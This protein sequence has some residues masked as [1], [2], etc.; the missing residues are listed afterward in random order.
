MLTDA[1]PCTAKPESVNAKAMAACLDRTRNKSHP[2]SAQMFTL[3][4]GPDALGQR[5]RLLLESNDLSLTYAS[6]D[7]DQTD[8]LRAARI[9]SLSE[10]G[11]V[12]ATSGARKPSYS[13]FAP[14]CAGRAVFCPTERPL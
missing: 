3:P 9:V 2:P 8:A 7:S 1:L 6:S 10:V 4:L 14:L 11:C 5:K 12:H 13:A